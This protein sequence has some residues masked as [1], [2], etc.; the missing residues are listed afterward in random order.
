MRLQY[1]NPFLRDCEELPKDIRRQLEKKLRLFSE[2]PRHPSL[3]I[4]K[5]KGEVKGYRNVFEGSITMKYRF[6]FRI[7]PNDVYEF[8]HCGTHTEI[9]GR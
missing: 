4:K 3:R 8:L 2:N 5:V 1:T 6:I 7:L 9:F